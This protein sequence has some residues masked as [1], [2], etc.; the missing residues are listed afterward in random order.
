MAALTWKLSEIR[1]R[2]RELTGR[3]STDDI[4]DADVDNLLNDYY[5]NYFPEDALVTNFDAFFTQEALATDNGEYTLAQT[6]VKLMEPMT[7]NGAEITFYQDKNYFFQMYPEDEQ[8]ITSST[9]AIGSSDTAAVKNSAF[10]FDVQ[11]QSYSKA[12]AETAFSGL[13]TVP[14][15]KYG[16]FCL[17]IESDGTITIYEADDNSTGYNSAAL[18]IAGLPDADSDTAYLGIITV[19]STD[20]GGF[21]PGTTALSDSAVTET[22]TNG[23]PTKRGTPS[24]ALYIHN[25]LFLRPKADDIYQFQAASEMNRPDALSS[26]TSLPGDTKWGPMIALGAAILYLAPRGGQAR[27][28]ELT[29]IPNFSLAD[30]RLKS[31][32]TK[33]RLAMRGRV[34]EPSF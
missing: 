28:E 24:G 1:A 5:Q 2:W 26:D 9:L 10:T 4:S 31:I 3:S 29:G 17:K 21:V 6:I 33:K 13:S 15:N 27:I 11:S 19:I 14:Q 18:A 12:S 32:R 7:I 8:Y 22:Y 34:A 23:D 25:K 16:A 30:Y 20:S